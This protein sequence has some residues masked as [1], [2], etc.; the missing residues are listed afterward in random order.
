MY[1]ALSETLGHLDLLE[2][3]GRVTRET[4]GELDYWRPV[5]DTRT[6]SS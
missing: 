3:A 6:A 4:R 1:L 2:Q 5:G